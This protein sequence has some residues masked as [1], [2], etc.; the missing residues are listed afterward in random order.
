MS[1]VYVFLKRINFQ[2]KH[3]NFQPK[4]QEETWCTKGIAQLNIWEDVISYKS[5]EC[6][7]YDRAFKVERVDLTS[8]EDLVEVNPISHASIYALSTSKLPVGVINAI[9]EIRYTLGSDSVM[10]GRGGCAILK[11]LEALAFQV[12]TLQVM[13]VS[14]LYK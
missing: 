5:Q 12:S 4:W 14:L 9:K 6:I 8:Q 13:P 10:L 7:E 1:I 3:I 11:N 2:L